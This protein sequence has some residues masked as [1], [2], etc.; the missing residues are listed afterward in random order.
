MPLSRTAGE[1]LKVKRGD[2]PGGEEGPLNYIKQYLLTL[3]K[4]KE[5]S[6]RLMRQEACCVLIKTVGTTS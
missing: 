4:K 5:R 1:Y 6:V 2:F 3:E